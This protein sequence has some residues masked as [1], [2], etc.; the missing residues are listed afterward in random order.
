M[1]TDSTLSEVRSRIDIVDI[2]SE[3]VPLK[4]AGRNFKGVC[5]FHSE[6][7]PSF[8]VSPEKQ[9]FHCF[10][11]HEGGDI[12]SFLMKMDG[13]T[14]P[15]A[16]EKLA[17]RA[18][19]EIAAKTG[20][21]I[22]K[23]EKENCYQANRVAA[24]HYH[25][26][27]K[28]APE[29]EG[30]RQYLQNRGV[31]QTEIETFR[32]G[33]AIP[34]SNELQKVYESRKVPLESAL[35]TGV[36]RTGDR[37][38]FE[39]FQGRI[40][41]PIFNRENRVVGLGGRIL[42][43]HENMAKYINS[44]DSPVYDKSANLFGLPQAMEAIRKKKRIF[45]VEGYL[46]VIT[47]HQFGFLESVAPLG[48]ALT[49]RQ[50]SLMKRYADEII[51]LFDADDAGWKAAERSLDLFLQQEISPKVLI[52]PAGEDPDTFLKKFGPKA[53]QEKL[54]ETRNLLAVII[55]K[56]LVKNAKDISGRAT[57]LSELKPYLL[58][59][60]SSLERN[61]Y[62][63]K[64]AEGLEVPEAWVFEELGIKDSAPE[65][66]RASVTRSKQDRRGAEE[67]LFELF[68]K[69][70]SIRKK[71]MENIQPDEF[72]SSDYQKF[73]A[74]LWGLEQIATLSAA[75]LLEKVEEAKF[76][77]LITQLSLRESP[78]DPLTVE[79]VSLDCIHK[80]KRESLKLK[81]GGLSAQIKEAESFQQ[82]DKVLT[83]LQEKQNI[84][85]ALESTKQS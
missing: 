45:L 64:L 41:F 36:I 23:E 82:T 21:R 76:K 46:D 55:D 8:T 73:A 80:I 62:I 22:S 43:S 48:T 12:F 78:M 81:L 30:A 19:V 50:I 39:G 11:C 40:I 68:L 3:Y 18:G 69:F 77:N 24:W 27:L 35:K 37:G 74:H 14:F 28:N 57:A 83:L 4:K 10:G 17:E 54:K 26:T 31:T 85:S 49:P 42:E 34:Y 79:L 53:L 59:L 67:I 47:M 44:P 70:E 1:F 16:L 29:A 9:I 5:P 33:F 71:V 75:Q 66:K 32:L 6:N 56:S 58:Q 13:L 63:R 51:V 65:V 61:L 20:P 72:L 25:E 38:S 52:L 2:V 15:E 7:T 84:L 60:S